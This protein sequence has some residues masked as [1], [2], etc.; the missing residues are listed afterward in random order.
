[1]TSMQNI[2]QS[3]DYFDE[4]LRNNFENCDTEQERLLI[5]LA[6]ITEELGELSEQVL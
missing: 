2:T 6:K 3:L 1:M 5:R 4:V